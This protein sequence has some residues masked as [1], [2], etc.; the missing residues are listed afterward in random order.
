[1]TNQ[2]NLRHVAQLI[3]E[4]YQIYD[5][6]MAARLEAANLRAAILAALGADADGEPDPLAY[7]RDEFP[8]LDHHNTPDRGWCG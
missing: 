6:L 2:L 7:L 3:S 4:I 1:L 8:E 5:A